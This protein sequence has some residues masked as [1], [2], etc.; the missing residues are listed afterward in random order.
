MLIKTWFQNLL[1]ACDFLCFNFT[2][3][4][5]FE[6]VLHTTGKYTKM[7]FTNEI[8]QFSLN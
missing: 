7:N 8:R 1:Q 4:K 2:I 6:N 5:E 3:I